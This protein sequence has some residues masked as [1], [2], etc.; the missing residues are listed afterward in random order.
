[1]TW[2]LRTWPVGVIIMAI[3]LVFSTLYVAK[4]REREA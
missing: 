1:V 4:V 2:W 3:L